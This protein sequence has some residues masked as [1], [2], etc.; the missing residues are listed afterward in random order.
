M[1]RVVPQ[2]TGQTILDHRLID[3][4]VVGI[5]VMAVI[6]EGKQRHTGGRTILAT[7]IE[8]A[9]NTAGRGGHNAIIGVA[10]TVIDRIVLLAVQIIC[11]YDQ[12]VD[13]FGV[14]VCNVTGVPA[15]KPRPVRCC[16]SI[17]VGCIDKA[18]SARSS[19]WSGGGAVTELPAALIGCC[20]LYVAE[21]YALLIYQCIGRRY[22]ITTWLYAY[23]YRRPHAGHRQ[24]G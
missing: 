21:E 13:G 23:V 3:I 16:R 18:G 15:G 22:I 11:T 24:H 8:A 20:A 7:A 9:A 14:G 5:E 17:G 1:S 12:H 6:L 4:F 2:D 10:Q 19:P